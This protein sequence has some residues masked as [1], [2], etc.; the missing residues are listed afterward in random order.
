MENGELVKRSMARWWVV[1]ASADVVEIAVSPVV[2][3]QSF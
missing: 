3:L 2:C 1:C